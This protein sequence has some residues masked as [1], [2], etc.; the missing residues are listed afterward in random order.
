MYEVKLL[1]KHKKIVY[2][3]WFDKVRENEVSQA[4]E[5]IATI[6][7]QLG[8]Q[9]FY[10]IVDITELKVFSPETKKEIVKQQQWIAD[11][12]I[13]A[14]DV[15]GSVLT[16]RQLQENHKNSSIQN[17]VI[18]FETVEKAMEYLHNV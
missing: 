8:Q 5:E 18:F 16:K 1:D 11:K 13:Q 9:K 10:I 14:C 17:A 3:K 6:Y 2:L 4:T 15:T 7:H 12:I